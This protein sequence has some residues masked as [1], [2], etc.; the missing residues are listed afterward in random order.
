MDG[1]LDGDDAEVNVV[2]AEEA[3]A[4]GVQAMH[5][6]DHSASFQ[7]VG[8]GVVSQ[9]FNVS[10]GTGEVDESDENGRQSKIKR[11]S[12]SNIRATKR[13]G[14]IPV[15]ERSKRSIGAANVGGPYAH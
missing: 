13:S 4:F 12:S 1:K 6:N 7:P 14:N 11:P 2:D 5:G 8:R 9:N 15:V 3:N 10:V